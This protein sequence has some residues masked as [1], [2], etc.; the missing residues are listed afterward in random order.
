MTAPKCVFTCVQTDMSF[1]ETAQTVNVYK[2]GTLQN[3]WLY[4]KEVGNLGT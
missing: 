2:K 4:R 3:I 1:E